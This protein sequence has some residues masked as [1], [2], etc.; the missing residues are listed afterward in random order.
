V[1]FVLNVMAFLFVGLEARGIVRSL[2]PEQLR[3]DLRFAGI[4]LALVIGVRIM[5]VMTY[6]RAIQRLLRHYGRRAGKR[7]VVRADWTA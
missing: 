2:P 3:H 5:L 1:V 4:V 7:V 6:N